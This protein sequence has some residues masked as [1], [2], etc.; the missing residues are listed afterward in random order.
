MKQQLSA[1]TIAII[2]G[3]VA[4]AVLL[5]GWKM[6]LAPAPGEEAPPPPSTM[7]KPP[8]PPGTYF[9]PG[10]GGA[11]GSAAAPD[12]AKPEAAIGHK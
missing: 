11:V 10:G 7:P 3:I 8:A 5:F 12:P 4:L 1:K 2:L 9:P 6:V